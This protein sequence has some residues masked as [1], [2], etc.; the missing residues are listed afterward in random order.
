MKRFFA[1]AALMCLTAAVIA[2]GQGT[3]HDGMTIRGPATFNAGITGTGSIG[4]LTAPYANLTAFPA[5]CGA[6]LFATQVAATPG[7]TQPAF[8]NLSGIATPAQGGTGANLSATGGTGQY[9]KQTG[10]GAN[11]SVGTIPAAD[12]PPIN[13]AAS[14]NGGVTG[15]LPVGNL[16]SG[17]GATSSTFWR[18]DGQWAAPGGG[19]SEASISWSDANGAFCLGTVLSTNAGSAGCAAKWF[20]VN[21]HTIT[22]LKVFLSTNGAGCTTPAIVSVRDVTG[23]SNLTTLSISNNTASFD[24]GAL[25]IAT[26]AG[27]DFLVGTTTISVSCTTPPAFSNFV[28]TYQ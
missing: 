23:A 19:V 14:G 8:S 21:A 3:Q 10:A 13:L 17:T 28:V 24:S 7:C 22:R 1:F 26:T 16:N 11:F 4:A 25:S 18:G 15:N 5:A 6:N 27:R 9:V 12:V 20:W 2:F